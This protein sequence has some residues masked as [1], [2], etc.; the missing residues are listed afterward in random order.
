MA[1]IIEATETEGMD[2]M[3]P[4]GTEPRTRGGA[5]T[6][7]AVTIA[8][9]L[10]VPYI[11]TFTQSGDSARRLSR[12]RPDRPIL[13]FTPEKSVQSWLQLLWGVQ[14]IRVD[15]VEHT[16]EMTRQVDHHLL[17]YLSLIHI[18]EPTR[19]AA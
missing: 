12:L 13:A 4:L 14:P 7:A 9:Q 11:C 19:P 18:S 2:R 15:R 3:P 10:D 1:S 6:R 16:D 8:R 5:V 17:Q